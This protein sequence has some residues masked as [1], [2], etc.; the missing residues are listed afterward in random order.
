MEGFAASLS[1][2]ASKRPASA[3]GLVNRRFDDVLKGVDA[4]DD[5]EVQKSFVKWRR[6]EYRTVQNE[7]I[8]R[9]DEA[10][11]QNFD[12]TVPGQRSA[13]LR[14]LGNSGRTLHSVLEDTLRHM[15]QDASIVLA[16]R[17]QG[18]T[19]L[20]AMQSGPSTPKAAVLTKRTVG[21]DVSS[22]H[23]AALM[24]SASLIVS[25]SR[26]PGAGLSQTWVW[27]PGSSFAMLL[28]TALSATA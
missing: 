19:S 25:N 3:A 27:A 16:T 20:Q 10:L 7:L 4:E 15:R 24:N 26:I 23:R 9:L 22:L 12:R 28:S 14:A 17:L 21:N 8:R 11:P 6:K 5:A 13:G 18:A 2:G 1:G